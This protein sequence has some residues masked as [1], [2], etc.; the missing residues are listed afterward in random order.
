[1]AGDLKSADEDNTQS[2][3]SRLIAAARALFSQYGYEGT[4][5]ASIAR[6]AGSAETQ[7]TRIFGGKAGLLEAVFNESWKPLNERIQS[8]AAEAPT[9][10]EALLRVLSTMI[11]AFGSDPNLAFLVLI[12]DRRQR[13][14]G[15]DISVSRGQ[16]ECNALV[17]E[18]IARGQRDGSLV[19]GPS[20]EAVTSALVG[21]AEAMIRDHAIARRA[22]KTGSFSKSEI[23]TVFEFLLAGLSS[24][25]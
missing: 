9:A 3:R 12:E 1:M 16:T 22:G 20:E 6:A 7:M 24:N 2:S 11:A 21:A 23:R 17:R 19:S 4:S 13:G 5:T 8:I 15:K 14:D 10:R 25:A 18:L